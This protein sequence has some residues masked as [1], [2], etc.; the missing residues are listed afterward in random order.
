MIAEVKDRL[1]IKEL[2]LSKS[3]IETKYGFNPKRDIFPYELDAFN[4]FTRSQ[5]GADY[6]IY[7]G[8]ISYISSNENND[9]P[10][11]NQN[12]VEQLIH[13]FIDFGKPSTASAYLERIFF[14]KKFYKDIE[15][16]EKFLNHSKRLLL[17]S[18]DHLDFYRN[19]FYTQ[20]INPDIK[21]DVAAPSYIQSEMISEL[22]TA[23]NQQSW[24]EVAQYSAWAKLIKPDIF[25]E[26]RITDD[27]WL[28]MKSVFHKFTE[29]KYY[30]EAISMAF[31]MCVLS[32]DRIKATK[33]GPVFILQNNETV[34]NQT[35]NTPVRRKF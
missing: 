31:Y 15:F 28:C 22:D 2:A 12:R 18:S 20:F 1:N 5:L 27:E 33:A 7:K 6:F 23:R 35:D 13:D 8:I 29:E 3:S 30:H 4:E 25:N 26:N 21:K 16:N 24:Y 19:Y 32:A 10:P 34:F 17:D 14:G 9:I 11:L